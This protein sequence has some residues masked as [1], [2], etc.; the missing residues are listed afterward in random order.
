MENPQDLS[1]EVVAAMIDAVDNL[2]AVIAEH[3]VR[4]I[5]A[6]AS[7]EI[8]QALVELERRAEM[9]RGQ[10]EGSPDGEMP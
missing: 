3:K 1:A 4:L 10:L 7:P 8:V 2:D 9:L 5:N 6:G